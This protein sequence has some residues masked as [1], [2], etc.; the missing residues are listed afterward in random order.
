METVQF[1]CGHCGKLMAVAVADVGQQVHCPHCQQI[2]QAPAA[3]ATPSD[4]VF[5]PP[6]PQETESIFAPE[7]PSDDLFGAPPAPRLEL[8]ASQAPTVRAIP[9]APPAPE[10]AV[11][12]DPGRTVWEPAAGPP[13]AGFGDGPADQTVTVPDSP[14]TAPPTPAETAGPA[15][16]DEAPAPMIV[17]PRARRS[18][19]G[20][21]FLI[22][23]IPYAIITTAAL[24]YMVYLYRTL[25]QTYK[26]ADPLEQMPDPYPKDG[27]PRR[28]QHDLPLPDKLKTALGQPLQ[29][30]DLE[31]KPLKVELSADGELILSLHLRNLSRNTAFNPFPDRFVQHKRES[32]TAARPY[33]Y[34]Q[35]G[36][37]RIYGGYAQWQKVPPG[38]EQDSFNGVLQ[39]G[40]AMT[41]KLITDRNANDKALAEEATHSRE[42]LL[43]RLHVR[44]GFVE[45]RGKDVS[46][47]AVIGVRFTAGDIERLPEA[48]ARPALGR[49]QT[50]FWSEEVALLHRPAAL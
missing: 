19:L 11:S 4:P 50:A 15:V 46:A 7:E 29:I 23:L 48:D 2:V 25:Q 44:R 47:T 20:A 28:V 35:V 34:L 33:T 39:P 5:T 13:P 10:P 49:P 26:A 9:P 24:G 3:A 8:P 38:K 6:S 27:G 42:P 16:L 41:A 22:I 37:G 1:T 21:M 30:G 14:W 43:W 18:H 17:P 36:G 32:P 12:A 31:V 40:A 45:V